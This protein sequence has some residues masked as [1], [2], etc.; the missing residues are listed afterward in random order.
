MWWVQVTVCIFVI[1]L[2]SYYNCH[3]PDISWFQAST[4]SLGPGLGLGLDKKILFTS[5]ITPV[6]RQ[7]QWLPVRQRVHF[8]LA[9]LVYKAMH[10][11]TAAYL[12]VDCHTDYQRVSHAGR[13]R[14]RSA[15]IDACC[16]PWTNTRLGDRS[17]AAAGPRLGNSLS[18]RI[19]QPDNDIGEFRRQ[20]KL[21]LFN[22]HRGG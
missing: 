12:V 11:A 19:R 1:L 5:L 6:L 18:A 16:V 14:L 2:N 15:D 13:R 17:F 22:L 4:K 9:L 7:L 3:I 10:D 20:L 8:K 21:S